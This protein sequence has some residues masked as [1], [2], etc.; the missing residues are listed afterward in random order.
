MKV[1]GVTW[2]VRMGI[3]ATVR[4]FGGIT[5]FKKLAIAG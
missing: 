5:L 1:A 2:P 4:L 3:Y